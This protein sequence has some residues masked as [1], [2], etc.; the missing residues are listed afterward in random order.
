MDGF[1]WRGFLEQWSKDAL[2][3]AEA[4]ERFPQSVL[5]SEWL[6]YPGATEEQIVVAETHLG[7]RLPPSYRTFLK[8]T[9]GW[10]QTT[11]FVDKLWSTEELEWFAVRHQDLIDTAAAMSE[12]LQAPPVLDEEYFVYGED[13]AVESYRHEYLQTALE[14]SEW[15]DDAIY[16]LNPQVVTTEGEWEAWFFANWLPGAERWRSFQ[17]MM[18]AEYQKFKSLRDA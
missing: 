17:E 8:I 2:R 4:A 11:P 13:Q 9:S 18:I 3:A 5:V 15:G 1:D 12:Q 16:L 10:R 14:I 6:G 7:T